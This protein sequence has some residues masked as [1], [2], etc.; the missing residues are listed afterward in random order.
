[1]IVPMVPRKVWNGELAALDDGDEDNDEMLPPH[2]IVARGSS[3][4][5]KTTFSMLEGVGRRLKGGDLRSALGAEM[6]VKKKKIP[7]GDGDGTETEKYFGNWGRGH[8]P[9]TLPHCHP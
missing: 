2:E 9:P 1:M 4:L 8:Q 3:I 6:G 5:P 7:P